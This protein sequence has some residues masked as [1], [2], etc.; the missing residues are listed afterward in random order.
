MVGRA[1]IVSRSI[2][3][4]VT[5]VH[6][7]RKRPPPLTLPRRQRG[8]EG[9][10]KRTGVR[11]QRTRRKAHDRRV[12]IAMSIDVIIFVW[13]S[14]GDARSLW[15][16]GTE[17]VLLPYVS[18]RI[19]SKRPRTKGFGPSERAAAA[20]VE[21]AAAFVAW[22]RH[23]PQFRGM[24]RGVFAPRSRRPETWEITP[25]VARRGSFPH[26]HHLAV[27]SGGRLLFLRFY[28]A[29]ILRPPITSFS[30]T[31]KRTMVCGEVG[32]FSAAQRGILRPPPTS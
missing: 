20:T 18:F 7:G 28:S 10:A 22:R 15:C 25:R 1:T 14:G 5:P 9:D 11:R 2:P 21:R 16:W 32:R 29:G 27:V 23:F 3:I 30:R 8:G 13:K 6:A 19:R 31:N 24:L 12:T 4:I 17:T 26:P